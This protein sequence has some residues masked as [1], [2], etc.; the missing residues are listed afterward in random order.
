MA[1]PA[2]PLDPLTTP[3]S[4]RPAPTVSI[5]ARDPATGQLG[6]AVQSQA[7]AVGAIVPWVEAGVGV[8][9]TQ[10]FTKIEYGPRGLELMRCGLTAPQALGALRENDPGRELRQV[11]MIDADGNLA[12]H[13]GS[14]CVVAAGHLVESDFAAQAVMMEDDTVWPSMKIA[15]EEA[16]GD[17]ADRLLTALAV[18]EAASGDT[19]GHH[20]A[21]LLVVSGQRVT[22]WWEGRLFDVRVDDHAQPVAEAR[23]LVTLHRAYNLFDQATEWLW[24]GQTE[25]AIA[26][27]DQATAHAPEAEALAFFT[28]V[29]RH[30]AGHESEALDA[31]HRLFERAPALLDLVPRLASIGMLPNEPALLERITNTTPA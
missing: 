23:R 28:A 31:F 21:A 18:A 20:S 30:R 7:F 8:V 29:A 16:S 9:V 6:V 2:H 25:A 15:Y 17:L 4:G 19:P 13:T 10:G 5:V 26:A 1:H 12:V 3:P 22:N 11:A 14:F 27:L 24:E